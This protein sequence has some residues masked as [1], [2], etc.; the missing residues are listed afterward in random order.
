MQ[1][2][3]VNEAAAAKARAAGLEVVMNSCIRTVHQ[4]M[5]LLGS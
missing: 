3:I 1:Q 4:R 2:G 5:A